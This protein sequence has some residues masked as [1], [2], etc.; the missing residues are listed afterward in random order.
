MIQRNRAWL[1]ETGEEVAVKALGPPDDR[2]EPPGHSLT[3]TPD[4][5][6][7]LRRHLDLRLADLAADR[8]QPLFAKSEHKG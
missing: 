8:E 4:G 6:L 2:T 1:F 7:V 3:F 5:K